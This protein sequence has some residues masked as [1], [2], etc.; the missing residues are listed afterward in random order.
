[1]ANKNIMQGNLIESEKKL[2][3][4]LSEIVKE[5][6]GMSFKFVPLH[7]AGIPDRICLLP[8]GRIFFAEI[9]TTKQTLKK[10]Q[11]LTRSK[12]L[13]LGFNVYI[14]DKSSDLEQ[15]KIEY[16]RK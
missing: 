8:G 15:I 9:K 13:K 4:K 3:R 5:M 10:L 2:E 16:E 6:G 11:Q 7:V 14:V 1:M 12:L